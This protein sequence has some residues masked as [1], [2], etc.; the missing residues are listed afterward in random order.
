MLAEKLRNFNFNT[1]ASLN[2][3]AGSVIKKLFSE[4]Y[5]IIHLAGH[6]VFNADD[7]S[8]S[9]MVIGKDIFLT[10]AEIAQMSSIPE[11]VFVNCCYLG[12]TEGLS[13]IHI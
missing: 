3:S 8:R 7:P 4:D 6:G 9:G 13:L 5:K 10:T 11:F 12:H 1:A 2:E